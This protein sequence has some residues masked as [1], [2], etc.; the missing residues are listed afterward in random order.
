MSLSSISSL[1][2]WLDATD[3]STISI[4]P[5]GT[6][7]IQWN[8]KSS[9]AYQFVPVRSNDRPGISTNGT[10]SVAILFNQSSSFQLMSKTKVAP[11]STLDMY[12]VVTPYSLLGPRQA[13][14][15]SPD[16]TL[17]ETDGRFNTQIYADGSE[18]FRAVPTPVFAQGTAIFKGELFLGSFV[19]QSPNYLQRYDSVS[20]SFNYF[21]PAMS[22]STTKALAVFDGKL[23]TSSDS[24]IEYYNPLLDRFVTSNM[25]VSTISTQ[26]GATGFPNIQRSQ[27]AQA[28]VV[29]KR[30]LYV[31]NAGWYGQFTQNQGTSFPISSFNFPQLYK[32]SSSATS[33]ALQLVT[34]F[35]LGGFRYNNQ[36]SADWR[37]FTSNM[38][39]WR[40][41][42]IMSGNAASYGDYTTRFNGTTVNQNA[43][44]NVSR[45]PTVYYGN[46]IFPVN[47]GSRMFIWN[48]N[49]QKVFARAQYGNGQNTSPGSGGMVAYRGRLFCMANGF[50]G[51]AG[52]SPCNVIQSFSFSNG[53]FSNA[54]LT[55]VGTNSIMATSANAQG[56]LFMSNLMIVHDG[57]LF[58]HGG[59]GFGNSNCFEYGNGTTLDRPFSTLVGAPIL[60]NI[61]KSANACQMYLNGTLVESEYVN[62]TYANQYAREMFIGGAAGLLC[63]GMSDQG[64]DHMEGAIHSVVQYSSNLSNADRQKV[65]GILAW[66][67]GIQNVL[68]PSHPFYSVRPT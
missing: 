26:Q 8:D 42:I 18:F 6:D 49:V 58:V 23:F 9:N 35:S 24:V 56:N 5:A 14:F 61:R 2:L 62:F 48:D 1:A 16:I 33:S 10:S 32:I 3:L 44:T 59:A 46:L 67:F 11:I 40:G 47:D 30:E 22:N 43:F 50:Y 36:D 51:N 25:A 41:D 29:H 64:S 66:Q 53:P 45:Y 21:G 7:V 52:I 27:H 55:Q 12:C 63:A 13:I 31:T 20:R 60:V 34:N 15:D 37:Q 19:N 39:S 17:C 57:K 28:L 65:E 4:S 68:P 38:F 54:L